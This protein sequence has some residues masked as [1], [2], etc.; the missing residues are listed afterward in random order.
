MSTA[1]AD[2]YRSAVVGGRS[3]GGDAGGCRAWR[4]AV[5]ICRVAARGGGVFCR[6][7]ATPPAL[8]RSVSRSSRAPTCSIRTPPSSLAAVASAGIGASQPRFWPVRHGRL[9]G[10]E[11]RRNPQHVDSGGRSSAG[12]RWNPRALPRCDRPWQQ[13]EP[14]SAPAPTRASGRVLT[15][16]GRSA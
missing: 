9:A 2:G 13:L 1:T 15:A 5:A 14:V 16:T 12:G 4:P 7:G 11:R 3:G 8:S 6:A 10:G